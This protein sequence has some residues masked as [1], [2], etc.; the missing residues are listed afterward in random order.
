MK[1]ARKEQQDD[2]KTL[3]ERNVA[4]KAEVALWETEVSDMKQLI[5]QQMNA[6]KI[7]SNNKDNSLC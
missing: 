7:T 3:Q 1:T 5:S 4:L 2:L 6:T